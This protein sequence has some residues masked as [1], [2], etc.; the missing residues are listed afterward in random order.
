[1]LPQKPDSPP[2]L[3]SPYNP[4]HFP[5]NYKYLTIHVL[6]LYITYNH[7]IYPNLDITQLYVPL[8]I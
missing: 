2:D 6:D 7:K 8:L 4:P 3:H 5:Q 1:M